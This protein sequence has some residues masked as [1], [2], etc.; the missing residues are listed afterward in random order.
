M[1]KLKM[2]N[3]KPEKITILD[4]TL[5]DG[6]YAIDYQFTAEDTS[7]IAAGLDQSGFEMI[8]IGHGFGMNAS[9]CGKGV[10]A[11][12]DEE[13]LDAAS[14]VLKRAEFGMFFIRE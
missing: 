10:A 9:N 14:Q 5:R 7:I 6:S 11:A 13:Y 8:E 1:K 2:N 3:K 4:C 12:T